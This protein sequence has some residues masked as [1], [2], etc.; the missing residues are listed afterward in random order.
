MRSSEDEEKIRQ[1]E[2]LVAE[3][4]IELAQLRSRLRSVA[5]LAAAPVDSAS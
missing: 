5:L 1:L 2:R 3:Q 4:E